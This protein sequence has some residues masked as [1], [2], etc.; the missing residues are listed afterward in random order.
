MRLSY[1]RLDANTGTGPEW[2]GWNGG[3]V[4]STHSQTRCIELPVQFHLIAPGRL[5]G[6]LALASNCIPSSHVSQQPPLVRPSESRRYLRGGGATGN[7]F[8][9]ATGLG[10]AGFFFPLLQPM[11]GMGGHPAI[12]QQGFQGSS[13]GRVDCRKTT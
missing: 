5:D 2:E 6:L 3:I 8:S 1:S 10:F 7:A 12:R 9:A 13:V 4:G 11:L